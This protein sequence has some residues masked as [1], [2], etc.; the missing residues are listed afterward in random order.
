MSLALKQTNGKIWKISICLS[1]F[2]DDFTLNDSPERE[3][4][5]LKFIWMDKKSPQLILIYL[6]KYKQWILMAE[7]DFSGN[8]SKQIFEEGYEY[9]VR[10]NKFVMG[11]VA[12]K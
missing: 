10:I 6:F 2:L 3:L 9:E 12:S 4:E 7:T 5:K 11:T 1:V 8:D